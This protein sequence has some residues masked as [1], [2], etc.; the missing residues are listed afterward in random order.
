[1]IGLLANRLGLGDE[2]F[3]RD[4]GGPGLGDRGG[5]L[6][7]CSRCT[8]SSNPQDGNHLF[9]VSQTNGLVDPCCLFYCLDLLTKLTMNL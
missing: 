1:M 7:V 3:Q 2:S 9:Q 5:D 8:Q 6:D 4:L